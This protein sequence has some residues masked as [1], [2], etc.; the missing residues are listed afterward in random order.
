M[1]DFN[2][3]LETFF[4]KGKNCEKLKKQKVS[5][6]FKKTKKFKFF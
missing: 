3:G 6:K 5:K 2:Q 1:D 4:K